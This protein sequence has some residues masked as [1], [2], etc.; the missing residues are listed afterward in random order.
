M[1][2]GWSISVT[3]RV[4]ACQCV[5]VLLWLSGCQSGCQGDSVSDCRGIGVAVGVTV[6][7]GVT[8]CQG[9]VSLCIAWLGGFCFLVAGWPGGS[10]GSLNWGRGLGRALGEEGAA[11]GQRPLSGSHCCPHVELNC[12]WPLARI[13]LPIPCTPLQGWD[14]R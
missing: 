2:V 7:P 5:R 10:W 6:Y 4:T 14:R 13:V 12:G 8:G 3:V 1:L 9:D 11:A